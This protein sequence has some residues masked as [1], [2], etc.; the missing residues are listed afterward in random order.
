MPQSTLVECAMPNASVLV[1]DD[2]PNIRA[3][4]AMCLESLGC[5]VHRAAG[6][7]EALVAVEQLD[8][9]WSQLDCSRC[10]RLL[11]VGE[12]ALKRSNKLFGRDRKSVV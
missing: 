6:A 3:T 2:E 5:V 4:L 9:L 1:V 8:G 10:A 11:P 12:F 7:R